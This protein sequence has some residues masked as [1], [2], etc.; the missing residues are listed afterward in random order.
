MMTEKNGPVVDEAEKM[1]DH[2]KLAKSA[3]L[4]P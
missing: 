1:N 2:Q 3:I 4:Y